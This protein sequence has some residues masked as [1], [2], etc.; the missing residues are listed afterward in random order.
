MADR[1][2]KQAEVTVFAAD[3]KQITSTTDGSKERLDT[4]G[5]VTIEN[6]ESPTKYQLKS[7]V[8]YTTG[9]TLTSASDTTL[10]TYTGD[11]VIDFIAVTNPN[12]AN[13]EVAIEIDGTERFRATMDGLGSTLGLTGTA[14]EP[15]WVQTANKQ[16]RYHPTPEI[17]FSTSFSIKAKATGSNTTVYHLVLYRER[18]DT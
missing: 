15:I 9:S 13:W 6:N 17:G 10:A 4:S 12:S 14:T 2:N 11:G 7:D 8:D 18:V 1:T 16:F 3:N 5:T